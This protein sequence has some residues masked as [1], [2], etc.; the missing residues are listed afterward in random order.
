MRVKQPGSRAVTSHGHHRP[1]TLP[2][3]DSDVESVSSGTGSDY[4]NTRGNR[5][6]APSQQNKHQARSD[7]EERP[8]AHSIDSYRQ[9]K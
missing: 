4:F 5:S 8:L 1:K 2:P 6:T 9:S 7:V 3:Q